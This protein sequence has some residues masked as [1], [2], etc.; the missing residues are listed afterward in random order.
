MKDDKVLSASSPTVTFTEVWKVATLIINNPTLSSIWIRIGGNDIPTLDNAD[1]VCAPQSIQQF[2]ASSSQFA[3]TF[4]SPSLLALG[5]GRAH[6]TLLDDQEKTAALGSIV[7][8][9]R[10]ARL[11]YYDRGALAFRDGNGQVF[12]GGA[13]GVNLS[14]ITPDPA[15]APGY[16]FFIEEIFIQVTRLTAAGAVGGSNVWIAD[17]RN[18]PYPTRVFGGMIRF[19]KNVVGDQ[20][21]L[22][23]NGDMYWPTDNQN[24]TSPNL[25]IIFGGNGDT[26]GSII[27][28]W[29]WK[30][31]AFQP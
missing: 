22:T 9:S 7:D 2:P 28:D 18:S 19:Y 14:Q 29:G 8:E 25:N 1:F 26:G 15:I 10:L 3:A 11:A 13:A 23:F 12:A 21:L 30:L 16:P 4:A 6:L 27:V 24:P 5:A 31:T 17:N 20:S